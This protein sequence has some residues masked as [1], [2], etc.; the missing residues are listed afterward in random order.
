MTVKDVE[1]VLVLVAVGVVEGVL[2]RD[3]V[4]D[5]ELVGDAMGTLHRL[6]H[7]AEK[8]GAPAYIELPRVY[9]KVVLSEQQND[10]TRA[11]P[12]RPLAAVY[13][14]DVAVDHENPMMTA[15]SLHVAFP[16][17]G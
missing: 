5:G 17:P 3:V 4:G 15:P 8:E 14:P 1:G 9:A 11:R 12:V 13:G 6:E 7:G 16:G 10:E 2:L